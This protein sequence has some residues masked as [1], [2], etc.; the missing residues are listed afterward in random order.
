MSTRLR[1]NQHRR[2]TTLLEQAL[3]TLIELRSAAYET[4]LSNPNVVSLDFLNKLTFAQS[5]IALSRDTLSAASH[6]RKTDAVAVSTTPEPFKDTTP[7]N[8]TTMS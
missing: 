3:A 7:S 1:E 4:V 8:E 2:L 6:R 5:L